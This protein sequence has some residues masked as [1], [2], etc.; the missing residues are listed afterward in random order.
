MKEE[1]VKDLLKKGVLI[2]PETLKDL[3]KE[4]LNEIL[5]KREG[6][7]IT[8]TKQ[9]DR[10]AVEVRRFAHKNKLSTQDVIEFYNNKY[11]SLR[12]ILLKKTSPISINKAK[13]TFTPITL[14]GMV[15]ELTPR[16]FILEDQ[17][18]EIEAIN[19]N[20]NITQDD[21][22]AVK[23]NVRE[24]SLFV[25]EI[26][27][28]DIS[29]NHD[30][31]RIEYTNIIL[32]P[33]ATEEMERGADIIFTQSPNKQTPKTFTISDNPMWFAIKRNGKTVILLVYRPDKEMT[34]QDAAEIIKKR[35]LPNRAQD[36][37]T[38]EPK[39][40]IEPI[41]DIIWFLGGSKWNETYKG[42]T[43]VSTTNKE[44]VRINLNTREIQTKELT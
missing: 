21:V 3:K 24:G 41:P 39:F 26:I 23:G 31:G 42:I 28:P 36:I 20:H 16:G 12:N 33:K 8:K 14:I 2:S 10:P 30:I 27:F 32:T 25:E 40:L 13:N 22:V 9:E 35:W 17:T 5:T 44:Y 11:N 6:V 19:N 34:K 1:M 29:L 4:D 38:T 18:G 43:L 7:V 37:T 15:R